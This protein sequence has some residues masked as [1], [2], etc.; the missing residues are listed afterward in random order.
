[1]AVLMI[2]R[3]TKVIDIVNGLSSYHCQMGIIDPWVDADEA[4]NEFGVTINMEIKDNDYSAIIF[5]VNHNDFKSL[6][7]Q[8]LRYAMRDN[9]VI[10]DV[11]GQL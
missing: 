2:S 6:N 9:G 4:Y 1:M 5:V 10:Y 11:K 8:T 3:N 7:E